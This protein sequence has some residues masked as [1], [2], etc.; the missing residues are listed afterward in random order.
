MVII[1][2]RKST[3]T[4]GEFQLTILV[5]MQIT[6]EWFHAALIRL[7]AEFNSQICNY[8]P[9]RRNIYERTISN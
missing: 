2:K 1:H 4:Q 6:M 7:V 9:I 3:R 8:S 5:I